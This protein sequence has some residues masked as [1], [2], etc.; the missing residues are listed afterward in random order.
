MDNRF[1]L[2]QKKPHVSTD[3]S[4]SISD[5][6]SFQPESKRVQISS[7]KKDLASSSSNED[8]SLNHLAKLN[9]LNEEDTKNIKYKNNL[10][11]IKEEENK[12]AEIPIK[13]VTSPINN[14]I[15]N[16]RKRDSPIDRRQEN[17]DTIRNIQQDKAEGKKKLGNASDLIAQIRREVD[18]KC[19]SQLESSKK[20]ESN[21]DSNATSKF[22]DKSPKR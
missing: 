8:I 21:K 5:Y 10:D 20:L 19:S 15:S 6:S 12:E 9:K 1:S 17:E 18:S 3:N 4:S 14:I 22:S 11:V 2:E 13:R 16:I 7:E